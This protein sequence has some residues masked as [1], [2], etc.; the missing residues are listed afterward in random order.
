MTS[1]TGM[2]SS[3]WETCISYRL[4]R[5][6]ARQTRRSKRGAQRTAEPSSFSRRPSSLIP[7]T[8]T[9]LKALRLP[10]RGQEGLQKRATH[11]SQ[12]SGHDQGP[13]RLRQPG[14]HLRGTQAVL[15]GH[16]ELRDRAFKGGQSER[17]RHP[18]LSGSDVAQQRPSGARPR[19][20][21]DGVGMCQKGKF[22]LWDARNGAKPLTICRHWQSLPSRSTSSSTLLCADSASDDHL[23]AGRDTAIPEAAQGRCRWPGAGHRGAGRDCGSAGNSVPEARCGAACQHGAKYAAETA[24][25]S[26]R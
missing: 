3:A 8:H 24:G 22:C 23:W 15:K 7:G 10:G 13:P 18:S 12:R 5:C 9:R 14:P 17:R 6:A 11:L 25:A 19:S 21:Q 16:R 1:T 4:G 2:L 20:L 26:D